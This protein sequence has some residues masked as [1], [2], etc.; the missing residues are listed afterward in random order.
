MNFKQEELLALLTTYAKSLT[1]INITYV[2]ARGMSDE[3][4]Q[5]GVTRIDIVKTTIERMAQIAKEL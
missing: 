2:L 4:R 3:A 5:Q 1:E